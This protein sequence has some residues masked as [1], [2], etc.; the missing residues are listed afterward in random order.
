MK[1]FKRMLSVFLLLTLT[2]FLI[3]P[4]TS[5]GSSGA[6]FEFE[7]E[8]ESIV[9]DSKSEFFFSV[10]VT[11]KCV[12]GEYSYIGSPI[13]LGGEPVVTDGN[14]NRLMHA[15]KNSSD[16]SSKQ[17]IKEGDVIK[18]TW[19]FHKTYLGIDYNWEPGVYDI[20]LSFGE[21]STVFEDAVVLK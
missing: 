12:S 1:K 9:I 14:G 2:A 21:S 3:L 16:D 10:T 13:K 7:I 20:K 4:V 5:C 8:P 19:R 6:V 18:Q 15:P 11:T 17:V